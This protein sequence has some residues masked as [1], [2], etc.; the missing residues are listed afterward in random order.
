MGKTR[1]F[2]KELPVDSDFTVLAKPKQYISEKIIDAVEEQDISIRKLAKKID[3]KH[4]QIIR[5]TSAENYN[6]DTTFTHP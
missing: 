3:M 4:P 1:N 6:I 5:V 2:I